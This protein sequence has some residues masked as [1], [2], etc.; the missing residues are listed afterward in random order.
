[1]QDA[2]RLAWSADG[3]SL[4]V[5]V[6]RRQDYRI[7]FADHA[8]AAPPAIRG[9]L[10]QALAPRVTLLAD[11]RLPH[12]RI[13]QVRA[14]LLALGAECDMVAVSGDEAAKRLATAARVWAH[15][16]RSGFKRRDLLVG[17]GG[18]VVCDLAGFVAATFMRGIPYALLP[19]SLIAQIDGAIGGKV[20]LDSAHAKNL[21]GG[22]HHPCLVVIARDLLD[23]LPPRELASGMAEATKVAVIAA[24]RLFAELER[25]GVDWQANG[26]TPL[27]LPVLRACVELK[28][29]LLAGDP[30]ETVCLDRELN[31][32]HT[33]GH[34]LEAATGFSTY[35]HGEAVA[36]GMTVAANLAVL[37]GRCAPATR[38]RLLEHLRRCGLPTA[39][40]AR[41][42][43][44]V[45][46][47]L[48]RIRAIRGG[49][50]RMVIPCEIGATACIDEVDA[51]E[52]R[53]AVAD[54]SLPGGRRCE[55]ASAW[56][57]AEA[58]HG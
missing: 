35:R 8:A 16:E 48:G 7:V 51:E 22:F 38:Q 47:A 4:A 9:A 30:F 15:L 31:F 37:L 49:L 44:A 18:G 23:S 41:Q 33:V 52:L 56:T 2:G 34:A 28:L 6:T 25:I 10:A 36:I 55:P 58:G 11:R 19:T 39:V 12:G 26:P 45:L 1:M 20:A 32:G 14:G 54:P 43:A 42:V 27:P 40:P 5:E 24:P 50:L 3:D 29:G 53:A 21:I 17:I 46:G 57:L 13:E